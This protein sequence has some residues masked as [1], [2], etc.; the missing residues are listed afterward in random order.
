[1]A[2]PDIYIVGV[3]IRGDQMTPEVEKAIRCS[4]T[5][6]YVAQGVVGKHLEKLRPRRVKD[7]APFY[8]EGVSRLQ[9]YDRMSATVLASALEHPPVTFAV[10]GHPLIYVY[11]SSQ[12]L[13]AASWL[14]LSVKLLPGVSSLDCILIDLG[15]DPA[16]YGLQMYEATELLVRR[17]P[18]QTDVP[19]LIWQVGSTEVAYYTKRETT[20]EQLIGLQNHLLTFYPANHAVTAV[21][22]SP[23]SGVSSTLRKFPLSEMSSNHALL[24]QGVTL[25]IPPVEIRAT[26]NVELLQSLEKQSHD[27]A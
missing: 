2:S 21:F 12:I 17:R 26:A 27:K 8:R 4:A 11:P 22:S 13:F 25:Y 10:Y 3:G 19:C 20:A 18:L 24:H 1:M 23:L 15:L 14:G 7:L 5:V 9:S 16:Y 6:F